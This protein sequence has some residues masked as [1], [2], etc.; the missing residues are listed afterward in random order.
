MVGRPAVGSLALACLLCR[1]QKD[2]TSILFPFIR[3]QGSNGRHIVAPIIVAPI[4]LSDSRDS[5]R[6]VIA[7]QPSLTDGRD[8]HHTNR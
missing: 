6:L 8:G 4:L 5:C 7:F 2:F 1:H 3:A